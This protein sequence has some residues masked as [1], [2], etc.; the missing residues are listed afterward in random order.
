[1]KKVEKGK[2]Q[3][4]KMINKLADLRYPDEIDDY[5]HEMKAR[6]LLKFYI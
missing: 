5:F 2:A 1:M 6:I 3:K 4:L